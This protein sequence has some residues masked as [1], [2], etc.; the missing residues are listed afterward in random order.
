MLQTREVF[1]GE[2]RAAVRRRL[3]VEKA[4]RDIALNGGFA[5][6]RHWDPED[7]DRPLVNPYDNPVRAL[8]VA[9]FAAA[10]CISLAVT[11]C[12]W[13]TTSQGFSKLVRGDAKA[14]SRSQLTLA[15]RR[16]SAFRGGCAAQVRVPSGE[17]DHR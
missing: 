13:R 11:L 8:Q 2:E 1:E 10:R 9:H 4:E 14:D 7:G 12:Q 5:S 3:E 17:A 6:L 15:E 16:R